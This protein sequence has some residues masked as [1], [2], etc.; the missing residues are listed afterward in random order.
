MIPARRIEA[1]FDMRGV[2]SIELRL[3]RQFVVV[4]EELNVRRAARRLGMSQPPLSQA[5]RR[6][7]DELGVELFDR[8]ARR[9]RLTE[10]GTALLPEARSALEQAA[11]AVDAARR[12]A[13]GLSGVLRVRYVGAAAY[14]VLPEVVR[15]F[16][17][18]HPDVELELLEATTAAQV[19][20]LRRAAADVGFVRPP[21]AGGD[22]L[23]TETVAREPLVVA[24]PA[25]HPLGSG[26]AVA[27]RDLA[28]EGFVSF[29][30]AEGPALHALLAAACRDAGFTM[31]VAQQAV[32]MHAI[33]ALVAA[34]L[35][36]ALV[37]ASVRRLGLPGVV[38]RPL[39][40][41]A[42][43]SVDLAVVWRRG[44]PSSVVTRFLDTVRRGPSGAAAR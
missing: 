8:A 29:P 34:G 2:S 26:G 41:S 7:E 19:D 27:L 35:G 20:A 39:E 42:D 44:D 17:R 16:R 9:F 24:L 28:D 22:E 23:R 43:L 15:G 33:V 3:F 31:R 40:G 12:A 32:Q 1:R 25:D 6:L 14:G 30:P 37:P 5:M 21:V 10:A 18:A 36:V 13:R 11:R 4:A 38:Y